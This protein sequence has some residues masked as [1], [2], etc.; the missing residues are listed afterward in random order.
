M[1]TDKLVSQIKHS[2]K[3]LRTKAIFTVQFRS[4]LL[5]ITEGKKKSSRNKTNKWDEQVPK[6]RERLVRTNIH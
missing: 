1:G 5:D 2:E 4:L 3:I 6:V